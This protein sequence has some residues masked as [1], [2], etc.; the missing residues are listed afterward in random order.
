MSFLTYK[1]K[2]LTIF[3]L[4]TAL[5]GLI[6]GNFRNHWFGNPKILLSLENLSSTIQ[7]NRESDII[8]RHNLTVNGINQIMEDS[9][10]QVGNI[11]AEISNFDSHLPIQ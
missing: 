1:E 11:I 6:I 9:Q 3:L 5:I 2:G 4:C 7:A 8:Q 10:G